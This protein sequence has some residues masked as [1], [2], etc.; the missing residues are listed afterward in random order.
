MSDHEPEPWQS[1]AAAPLLTIETP[2]GVVELWAHGE[3]RFW[4]TAPGQ[5]QLVTGFQEA[6]RTA[7]ELAGLL[8]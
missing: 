4:I 2:Q 7:D 3:D 5:E 1:G 6:E 8:E